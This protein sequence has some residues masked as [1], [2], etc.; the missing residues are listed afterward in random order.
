MNALA[1]QI[2]ENYEP[3]LTVVPRTDLNTVFINTLVPN[4]TYND[5]FGLPKKIQ[6]ENQFKL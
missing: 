1:Y 2:E 4:F 5:K 3:T 6:T